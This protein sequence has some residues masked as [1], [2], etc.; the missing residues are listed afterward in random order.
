MNDT[1]WLSMTLIP[2]LAATFLVGCPRRKEKIQVARDGTVNIE[3]EMRGQ[4]D[5]FDAYPSEAT[6][7]GVEHRVEVDDNKKEL[8]VTG[9]Q[10]FPPDT[11]L[12]DRLAPADDPDAD[13]QL[14][15]PTTLTIREE[16]PTTR[17]A[18]HRTYVPRRWAYVEHWKDE[19]ITD[20]V[21]EKAEKPADELTSDERQELVHS[22]G[23]V[24]AFKQLEFAKEALAS[25]SPPP[26]RE[27]GLRAR[28]AT[29]AFYE[30]L[31]DDLNGMINRCEALPDD[32]RDACLVQETDRL[33]GLGHSAFVG[34][35]R[36][37]SGFGPMAVLEF[38]NAYDRATRYY[39]YTNRT[40][41][42]L[43]EL[44]ITMPGTEVASNADRAEC[45]ADL[46]TCTGHW[47]F[48]GK[49]FRDR[50]FEVTMITWLPRDFAAAK[51]D[52]SDVEENGPKSKQETT[53]DAGR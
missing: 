34:S 29:L 8:V 5:Q 53:T 45:D 25:M 11:P 20:D 33:L 51:P 14:N 1:R 6:G 24:E 39:D 19:F 48:N 40:G 36:D 21:R 44:E 41:E 31:G 43:F 9:V 22:F 4:P 15:F 49:A 37:E 50:L 27:V 10:E 18:F 23:A 46:G 13:L 47:D 26:P 30:S 28:R 3:L 12:P 32:A 52:E 17:F 7:W 38:Q 2:A 42:N 16:G 35:L